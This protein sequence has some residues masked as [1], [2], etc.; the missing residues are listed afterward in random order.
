MC[1]QWRRY[2]IKQK[3]CSARELPCSAKCSAL[4]ACPSA[5][6]IN[7]GPLRDALAADAT[8][9]VYVRQFEQVAPVS[10]VP[11]VVAFANGTLSLM[12]LLKGLGLQGKAVLPSFTYI[13]SAHVLEWVG[14]RPVWA[15]IAPDS[16]C[17]TPETVEAVL[18]DEVS[19]IMAV[20]VFGVPCDVEGLQALA[21]ARGIRLIYDSAHAFGSAVRGRKVGG[22]GRESHSACMPPG[23]ADR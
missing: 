19:V 4:S 22:S 6:R 1:P 12:M 21:D 23:A 3:T 17:V 15:D 2:D 16:Y 8:N 5:A 20:P 13:A 11:H 10:G 14:L 18:D 9:N 7:C